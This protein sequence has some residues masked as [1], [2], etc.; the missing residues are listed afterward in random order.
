MSLITVVGGSRVYAPPT[1]E[2][3]SILRSGQLATG[4]G[5][6]S[7]VEP[8]ITSVN[9]RQY[10]ANLHTLEGDHSTLHPPGMFWFALQPA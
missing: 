9:T 10:Y 7:A 1:E 2:N 6:S 3:V 8:T 4:D 5:Y